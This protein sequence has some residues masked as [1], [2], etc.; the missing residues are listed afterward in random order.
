MISWS[1]KHIAL[2]TIL[3][4]ATFIGAFTI[5][6]LCDLEIIEYASN[7]SHNHEKLTTATTEDHHNGNKHGHDHAVNH[8]SHADNHNNSGDAD[9]CC[10]D[11]A[12]ILETSLFTSLLKYYTP[13]A[14]YFLTGFIGL[15]FLVTS[16]NHADHIVYHEY[17]DPP[18][19]DGFDLRIVIQSFLN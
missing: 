18:P 4:L 19:M 17:D 12:D 6:A 2:I 1:S 15:K 10:D 9:E 11:A 8:Q 14:K 5:N 16:E 13:A 3:F 7:I